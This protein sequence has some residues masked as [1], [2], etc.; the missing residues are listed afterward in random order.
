LWTLEIFNDSEDLHSSVFPHVPFCEIATLKIFSDGT[1]HFKFI[2]RPYSV[3]L[4][5]MY[6]GGY[7][8]QVISGGP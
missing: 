3:Q 4:V 2:L 5:W 8:H 6:A 7:I 1:V